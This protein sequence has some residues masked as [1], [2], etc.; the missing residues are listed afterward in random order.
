MKRIPIAF[1]F[2]ATALTVKATDPGTPVAGKIFF[3]NQPMTNSSAG[4]KSVFSSAEYIYARLELNGTTIKDAFKIKEPGK[5]YPFLQC[6]VSIIKD[7]YEFGGSGRNYLLIKDDER[8]S[9]SL[10]FDVFPEPSRATTVF[11]LLDDFSAGIG[12]VPL[13]N[14]IVNEKL[15]E[16]K[17]TVKVRLYVETQDSWGTYQPEEKWPTIE[18]EFEFNFRDEDVARVLDNNKQVADN[19]VENAFRYDKLPDIFYK[20]ATITDPKATNAKIL[21]IIKRDLPQRTI[22]KMAIEK[23]GTIWSIAKDDYGLPKYRYFYPGVYVA[24]KINGKCYIGRVT[25]RET[26]S[27][28]GTFGPLQVGFTSASEQDD[29]GIDCAKVK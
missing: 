3:S 15:A 9:S 4:S 6:R 13:Y 10:N 12:F 14:I 28:G 16:G 22:L 29:K 1:F 8:A 11:S 5:G 24:Y 7:G 19:I 23:T 20:S 25:L 26:Y 27:G 2:L 18:E 17:Y 21:A